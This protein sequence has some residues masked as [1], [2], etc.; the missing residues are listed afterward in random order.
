[1]NR[2]FFKKIG[3]RCQP[4]LISCLVL[5][6]L[7]CLGSG[8]LLA[9]EPASSLASV[10]APATVAEASPP[11]RY[12]VQSYVVQGHI[13]LATN[14]LSQLFVTH[15]GTHLALEDLVKAASDLHREY[16]LRGYPMMSVAIAPDQ[17]TN[18]IVIL[19][20]FQ[21]AVPQVV[22]SGRCLVRFTNDPPA[23]PPTQE[24][25][26][27]AR[28]AMF[29]AMADQKIRDQA[30]LLA[31]KDTRVHVV[32]TNAGPRFT[33]NK[34]LIT[35]NSALTP[36]SMAA[37]LTNIDGAFGTNVGFDGIIAAQN[38]LQRAYRQRGF[39]TVAVGVPQQKLTNATVKLEVSEGRLAVINVTGNR[40]F[41]S[42]NVMRALPSLHTN[43]L[44]NGPIFQ[45]ELNRANANQDRQIYPLIG[46][47]PDPGSSALNL[48][49]KDQLPIH[50][51]LD[52]NNQNSPGTPDLRVNAS[53]VDNN[54]WQLE[55]S[56]GIQYGF[57]P[58]QYKQGS[59]WNFYDQPLIAN[60][61]GFYRLPLGNPEPI[62][63]V[64]ANNPGSFGYSEA[65][66][67]FRLPPP[68]GRSELNIYGSRSTSDTG[69]LTPVNKTI[70][71][72]PGFLKVTQED[73]QEDTTINQDAGVRL[74]V[75]AP[76]TADFQSGFTGGFDYKTYQIDSVKTNNFIFAIT[77]FDQNG[78]ANTISSFV[79]S[80]VPVTDRSLEYLPLAFGYNGAW[81]NPNAT[82][83]FGLGGTANTWYSSSTTTNGNQSTSGEKS[84]Q[85]ITGSAKS[86]GYWF[87]LN[88]TLSADFTLPQH[89]VVSLHANGQWAS[90]PLISTEQY[91]IGGVNSVRGYHE[92]E[93]FGDTG[94]RFSV[95]SQTPSHTV[96]VV[97]GS[98]PLTV[99]GLAY[100]DR[101][102]S[103]LLDP[104]GRPDEV[105]LW[106]TGFGFTASVGSHWASRF[107][108]SWPLIGTSSTPAEVP[109]F[110][111][112]L[113]AQF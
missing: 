47:G 107:L 32:S 7:F 48:K 27:R 94:W 72:I 53:A 45:A 99:R 59:Q 70:E 109:V 38:E 5:L 37:V 67:Q 16:C 113:S 105:D 33:V 81:R 63:N 88:P 25:V 110:S 26:E 97:Y 18:G 106:S 60:Y 4:G 14:F 55:H 17:I 51:K 56:L 35:G 24:E 22:V 21:T 98:Q 104:Q 84:L 52:F 103:Y 108:F 62:E 100:M 9:A 79:A 71:D 34:Y 11:S 28:A 8:S 73:N 68:T 69:L 20:V 112:D 1:M 29:Q 61:S 87:T 46:P 102:A 6:L 76:A 50:G 39:V 77:T 54:L 82:I 43:M 13:L 15:T 41:S 30:A 75:P 90:E 31:A 10:A 93:N 3:I 80:P 57:S 23:V 58:E 44:L 64:I 19:N 40:Y 83:T 74:S 49:V 2:K 65:T 101:A 12:D 78:N 85:G 111:F 95:E 36:Q 89:W 91:G 92:G 42:N 66:R 96:G 86:T